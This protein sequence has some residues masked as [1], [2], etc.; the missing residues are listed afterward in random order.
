M[1]GHLEPGFGP[2]ELEAL[3]EGERRA[4][5]GHVDGCARCAAEYRASSD[6]LAALALALPPVAPPPALRER[7]LQSVAAANRF[8]QFADR[9]AAIIDVTLEKA[10]S[11][12]GRIDD[13]ASWKESPLPGVRLY[14]L[15]GGPALAQAVVGFVR[16]EPG[17]VFPDHSHHGSE[18]ALVLQGSCREDNGRVARRGDEVRMDE[19]TSH[20]LTALPGPDFIYVAVANGGFTMF[21]EHF[22]PG[23]PR[24]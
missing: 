14:H 4:V 15:D 11:L 24:V 22:K 5:L 7:L 19:G 23:D 8:E 20:A 10:R 13:A 2:L 1:T 18:V 21:G 6:A 12:L 16:I 9:V 3:G 17:H